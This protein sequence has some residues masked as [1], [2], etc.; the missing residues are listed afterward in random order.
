MGLKVLLLKRC[1]LLSLV[2][3]VV[4]IPGV[5]NVMA[6]IRRPDPEDR[7]YTA[8]ADSHSVCVV[9]QMYESFT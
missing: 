1:Q 9:L 4:L 3:L 6:I 5:Q 7:Q 8:L 2:M